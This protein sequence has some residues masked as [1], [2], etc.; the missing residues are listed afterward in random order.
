MAF[1]DG[2]IEIANLGLSGEQ[3]KVFIYLLAI[4]DFENY[5]RAT[6]REIANEL[7]MQTPNV[8]RTFKVLAEHKIIIKDNDS[9]LYR[10]NT[11][12]AFRGKAKNIEKTDTE[13]ETSMNRLYNK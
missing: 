5:I 1:Q 11:L 9:Q 6:Q 2:L 10:M 4:L 13:I 12:Y 3:L 8:S 7:G